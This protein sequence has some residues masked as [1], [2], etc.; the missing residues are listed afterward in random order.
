MEQDN[1]ERIPN[2]TL[3][4]HPNNPRMRVD[5]NI[6]VSPSASSRGIEWSQGNER[7]DVNGESIVYTTSGKWQQ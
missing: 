4:K 3:Q 7:A 2:R 1:S 5:T 6:R